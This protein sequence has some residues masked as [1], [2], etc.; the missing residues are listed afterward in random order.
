MKSYSDV[1]AEAL[2]SQGVEI[3]TEHQKMGVG[4]ICLAN[5]ALIVQSSFLVEET[6]WARGYGTQGND[7]KTLR[8]FMT[9]MRIAPSRQTRYDVFD[10]DEPF[11]TVDPTLVKRSVLGDFYEVRQLTA[12]KTDVLILNRGLTTFIDRDQL[13]A[14]PNLQQKTTKWLMDL[15]MR[16]SVIEAITLLKASALQVPVT[17]DA[18]P[19]TNPDLQVEAEAITLANV[20]GFRPNRG[21]IGD[22]ASFKRRACFAPQLN[23]G[24]LAG[25]LQMTDTD[26]A[27]AQKLKQVL[28]NADRYASSI[29]GKTEIVGSN[30]FLYT[31]NDDPGIEDP[32]NIVRLTCNASMGGGEYAAYAT[33]IGL[34][35]IAITVEN[36][37]LF[38]VQHTTGI[39]QLVIT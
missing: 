22:T 31:A 27:I 3:T 20:T 38:A 11:F 15:I 28:T 13:A 17:W 10:E 21:L 30:E 14:D 34:K 29:N 7:L 23:A 1:R 37:E 6:T 36:Y 8:D 24:A 18:T 9:P 32:T 16:A 39:A 19:G 4:Q 35:K 33:P 12:T 2:A 26:I 5:E 25:A